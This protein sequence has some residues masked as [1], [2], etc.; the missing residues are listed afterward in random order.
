[1]KSSNE[2][3][4][5]SLPCKGKKE[6]LFF[7]SDFLDENLVLQGDLLLCFSGTLYKVTPLYT[8]NLTPTFSKVPE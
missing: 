8:C 4:V 2:I 3:K 5:L 1:M 6:R 7:S